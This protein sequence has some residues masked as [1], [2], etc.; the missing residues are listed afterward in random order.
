LIEYAKLFQQGD[1]TLEARQQLLHEQ[2][3]GLAA[4]M[5]EMKAVLNRLDESIP[6]PHIFAALSC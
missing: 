1:D 2:C 4:R 3:Q 6:A 5:E